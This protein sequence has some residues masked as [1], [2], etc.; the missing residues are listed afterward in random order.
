[1]VPLRA[2]KKI[3]PPAPHTKHTWELLTRTTDDQKTLYYRVCT[4]CKRTEFLT[5]NDATQ[6]SPVENPFSW[7]NKGPQDSRLVLTAPELCH[8]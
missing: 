2:T 3:Q 8:V 6:P 1:M 4:H 7:F 5:K